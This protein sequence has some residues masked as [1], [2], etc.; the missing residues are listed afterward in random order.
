MRQSQPTLD[1]TQ[2]G[3]WQ[4]IRGYVSY[5]ADIPF[6]TRPRLWSS[7]EAFPDSKDHGANMGPIW[8]RQD[9]AGPMLA[10]W[11]LLSGLP[12]A[13]PDC[14]VPDRNT[15]G[16]PS[17]EVFRVN[18]PTAASLFRIY[19]RTHENV[20]KKNLIRHQDSLQLYIQYASFNKTLCIHKNIAHI[21]CIC[22]QIHSRIRCD[23]LMATYIAEITE[24]GMKLI[25][26]TKVNM[27]FR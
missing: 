2:K 18:S 14:T 3:W 20:F 23:Q 8:G 25:D 12:F 24:N 15:Q 16:D 9:P 10:P 7:L 27:T 21:P 1:Q 6:T 17:G 4:P 11:T 13:C 5:A 22:I 26:L 19:D